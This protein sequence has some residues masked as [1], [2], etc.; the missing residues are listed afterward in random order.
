MVRLNITQ[1]PLRVCPTASAFL[2]HT[3]DMKDEDRAKASIEPFHGKS[4]LI[5][6]SC[7]RPLDLRSSFAP[8]PLTTSRNT[9]I[10]QLNI[11]LPDTL[12][13]IGKTNMLE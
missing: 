11:L 13:N 12:Q 5:T 7:S 9:F 10:A 8:V 4:T 1:D 2:I 6:I 3:T